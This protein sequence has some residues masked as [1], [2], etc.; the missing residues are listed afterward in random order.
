[1]P[2]AL[3]FIEQHRNEFLEELKE[4]LSLPSISAL[5]EH[6]SDIRSCAE[7]L[8]DH[9]RGIGFPTVWIF[10]TPGRPIV[11]AQWSVDPLKP[12]VL[13]YG[14]Y[15][16]QPTD[17]IQEWVSPPFLPEIREGHIYSRGA[18]DDKGQIFTHIKAAEALIR[19]YGAPPV[20]LKFLIEG[21]EEVGS[22]NLEVFVRA[23]RDLLAADVVCVSDTNIGSL[24][25]PCLTCGLRGLVCFEIMI[26]TASRD[27]HSGMYG[28]TVFNPLKLFSKLVAAAE[29]ID[30]KILIP[31]FYDDVRPATDEEKAL[32]E[33]TPFDAEEFR[34]SIGAQLLTGEQ[35]FSIPQ[36]LAFRPTFEVHGLRGGFTGEGSKTVIPCQA[37]VKVSMR[38]VPN[39]D[40]KVIGQNF[41]KWVLDFLPQGLLI[42]IQDLGSG[43]WWIGNINHPFYKIAEQALSW[44]FNAE[45]TGAL[46]EGG[47]IPAVAMF[48]E[49]LGCPVILFGFSLDSDNLHA[50]NERMELERFFGGIRA[51]A[52]FYLLTRDIRPAI[53]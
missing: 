36:R 40:P 7:W 35:A 27:L 43:K 23:H 41:K 28:G 21:E 19:T 46:F 4:F 51:L 24:R 22:Q 32:L 30:G 49:I 38:L 8:A 37:S 6:K 45:K 53:L 29:S 50:P 1:M 15:D 47:S 5:P 25:I 12:T 44:A 13:S 2:K 9:L 33:A 48:S 11:Y 26:R 42:E 16:V 3:T 52:Y 31:G 10:E 20:N 39:Q 17:P 34:Q 14:H 18:S